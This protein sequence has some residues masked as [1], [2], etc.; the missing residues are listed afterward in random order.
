LVAF[1]A[2]LHFKKIY[3]LFLKQLQL[4]HVTGGAVGR[5]IFQHPLAT[6][7]KLANQIA[8]LMYT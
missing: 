6:A 4:G 1:S 7:V 5:N 3:L 2:T 8:Q